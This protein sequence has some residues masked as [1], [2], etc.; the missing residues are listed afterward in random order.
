[1]LSS[2]TGKC[3]LLLEPSKRASGD[4]FTEAFLQEGGGKRML[5]EA[6]VFYQASIRLQ[7][8]SKRPG[9]GTSW[10]EAVIHCYQC[11]N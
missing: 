9:P 4:R 5:A 6:F 2:P 1:M 8:K 7:P 10:T 3:C 11:P